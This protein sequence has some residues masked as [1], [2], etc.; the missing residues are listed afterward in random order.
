MSLLTWREI[1]HH[2]QDGGRKHHYQSVDSV[3]PKAQRRLTGL[4]LQDEVDHLYR[5]RVGSRERLWGFR[6]D[7]VF[8]IL[9]W[10][11]DHTVYPTEPRNT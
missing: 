8:Q 1:S 5:F 3:I 6:K 11:P 10:D 2:R 4:G 9:W 7:G